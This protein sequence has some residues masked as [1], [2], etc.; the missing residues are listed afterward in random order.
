MVRTPKP[1]RGDAFGSALLAAHAGENGWHVVEREDGYVEPMDAAIYLAAPVAWPDIDRTAL[2]AAEG[3]ILDVGAGG[4]RHAIEA[5]ARGHD[6]VALDVSPGAL[7]VCRQRG[8]DAT[9]LGTVIDLAAQG[10][11]QFDT[12]LCLGNNLG[13]LGSAG[14]ASRMFDAMRAVLRPGGKLIGTGLDPYLTDDPAHLAFH[15]GNR[16]RRRMTG[17]TVLRVRYAYIATDWFDYLF[18]SP[19]ELAELAGRAGWRVVD[20]T[21]P[22]PHYLAILQPA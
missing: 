16:K 1:R 22:D 4:G 14:F 10:S 11:G 21:T 5:Q 6:V 17:R 19:A 20:S 3:G 12:L 15:E 8:V 13:L 18:T 7:E 9:F 2:D